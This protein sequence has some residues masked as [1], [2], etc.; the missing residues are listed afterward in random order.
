MKSPG[1]FLLGGLSAAQVT[2]V[3][4]AGCGREQ[5]TAPD[6]TLPATVADLARARARAVIMA[7]VVGGRLACPAAGMAADDGPPYPVIALHLPS[8]WRDPP[9]GK[10]GC[11]DSIGNPALLEVKTSQTFAYVVYAI[12]LDVPSSVGPSLPMFMRHLPD[13]GLM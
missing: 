3:L 5:A 1:F 9:P 4:L 10:F 2:G 6:T 11:D 8:D 7:L 13:A 12:A